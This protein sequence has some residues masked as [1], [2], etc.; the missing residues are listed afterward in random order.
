MKKLICSLCICLVLALT[1]CAST[2]SANQMN[3]YSGNDRKLVVSIDDNK[4][5]LQMLDIINN[6]TEFAGSVSTDKPD[7]IV[8]LSPIDNH[9][10]SS[11]Y[12]VWIKDDNIIYLPPKLFNE[13][14]KLS[15][16]THPYSD[17]LKILDKK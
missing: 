3:V 9:N 13:Q 5:I 1:A 16:S 2:I 11:E 14:S 12:K 15:I 17:F 7:Y 8:E 6:Y 10:S 4:E